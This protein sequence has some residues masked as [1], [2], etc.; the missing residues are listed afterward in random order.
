LNAVGPSLSRDG[1]YLYY[2][3]RKKALAYDAQF[4]L[5][6]I[7]RRNRITGE[8]DTITNAPLSAF[9]PE[10]SP[11]ANTLVY[12]TRYETETGLRIRDLASGEEKWLKYPIQRDDQESLYTRDF[13]PNYAFT[14]D[15]KD[16]VVTWGGK[17][18]RVSIASGEVRDIPFSAKVS[19]QLGPQLNFP[20]RVDEGPIVALHHSKPHAVSRRKADRVLGAYPHLFDGLAVGNPEAHHKRP[21]PRVR[22]GVVAR[23][24]VD[25]LRQLVGRGRKHLENP[26]RRL[27]C[28]ATVNESASLL[29][30]PCMV[31]GPPTDSASSRCAALTVP[32]S[33]LSTN[34]TSSPSLIWFGFR[35]TAAR[36][37]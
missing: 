1:K 36:Q 32:A 26:R 20:T 33:K 22:T 15:S 25:R 21:G 13:L 6:Q 34:G 16:L 27:W 31:R 14:P 11:D 2:A 24:S 17:I 18:H 5:S 37:R 10:I 19:R 28:P 30:R 23:R 9:R 3:Q 12:G 7:V 8:E 29:S 4:P 35:P